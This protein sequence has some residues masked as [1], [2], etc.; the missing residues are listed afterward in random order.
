[1]AERAR[2]ATAAELADGIERELREHGDAERA[3]RE[4]RYLKSELAF[5]G[6]G[7][8]AARA[9][10][11]QAAHE[12]APTRARLLALVR[13]LWAHPVHERRV[14]AVELLTREGALLQ[15]RDLALVERL[16]R[17]SGSWA[18]V[19][20]L[21]TGVVAPLVER[22]DELG[23]ELDRWARDEDFWVRRAALLALLPA[24]RRG[25]GDFA[26]F[27]RYAD[28]MLEEREFFIRKAIGWVLRETAKRRPG[29]V[30]EWLAPRAERASGVTMREAVRYLPAAQGAELLARR[31][32]GRRR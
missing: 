30:C 4:A 19:D 31:G 9:I 27:G 14:V 10:A 17:Q 1:V 18:Y 5:I 3:R 26:R 12:Q 29:L 24:L 13:A 15:A 16:L 25:G 2:V 7:V 8:P 11:R 28:A 23:A 21:A 6:T 20:A 22:H 32:A